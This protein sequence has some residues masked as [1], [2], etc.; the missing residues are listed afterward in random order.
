ML[1]AICSDVHL[2]VTRL[3]LVAQ[4]AREVGAQELW[5]LGDVVDALLGAPPP[6]LAE[7]VEVAVAECDL[8]LAGNHELWCLQ[9]GLFA[10]E[11]AETTK[12]WSAV[13]ER[14]RRAD[15]EAADVASGRLGG[16]AAGVAGVRLKRL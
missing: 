3:R 4:R 8:V 10:P 11:T 13:E 2:H 5:C 12:R 9:R 1:I 14:C 16:T 15:G 7:A 6:V